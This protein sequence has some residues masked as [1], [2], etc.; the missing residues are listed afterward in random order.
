M[1]RLAYKISPLLRG[2]LVVLEEFEESP[3]TGK[4]AFTGLSACLVTGEVV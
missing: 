3:D 1:A 2:S 4:F